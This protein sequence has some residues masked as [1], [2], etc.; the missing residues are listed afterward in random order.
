MTDEYC[1]AT[2]T[3]AVRGRRVIV[4]KRQHYRIVLGTV[5][6]DLRHIRGTDELLH[7]T[8]D[9]FHG[10]DPASL[11][12]SLK[13][14]PRLAVRD[15]YT[16]GHRLH[17]DLSVGNIILVQEQPFP[18]RRKGYLID[19]DSSCELDDSGASLDPG[20]AVSSLCDVFSSN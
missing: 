14:T 16:L 15:A 7:A 2:W 4:D 13:F 6:Y 5:G 11:S 10:E 19:W 8:F 9:A 18:A 17:R 1:F 20:R 3:R 12:R